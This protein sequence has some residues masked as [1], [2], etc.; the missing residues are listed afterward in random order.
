MDQSDGMRSLDM[1]YGFVPR[2]DPRSLS[3]DGG[4]VQCPSRGEVGVETCLACRHMRGLAGDHEGVVICD[5]H[6]DMMTA[7]DPGQPQG[8][9]RRTKR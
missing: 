2:R 9:S 1:E 7:F 4:Q 3:I 6:A 8:W 5:F